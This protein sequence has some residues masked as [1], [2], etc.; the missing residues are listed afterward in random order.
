MKLSV[1]SSLVFLLTLCRI[2]CHNRKHH[3]SGAND[4]LQ[5]PDE[6]VELTILSCEILG[7]VNF[8]SKGLPIIIEG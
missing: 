6:S 1:N 2:I 5:L 4:D 8:L 7:T 3:V